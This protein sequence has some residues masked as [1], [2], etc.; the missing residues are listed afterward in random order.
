ML[1]MT[2]GSCSGRHAFSEELVCGIPGD[3]VNVLGYWEYCLLELCVDSESNELV[4]NAEPEVAFFPVS[5]KAPERL[6]MLIIFLIK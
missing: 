3:S 2:S 5:D 6:K 4:D 1:A